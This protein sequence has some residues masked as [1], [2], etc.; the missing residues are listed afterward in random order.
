MVTLT[1]SGPTRNGSITR[2]QGAGE[3]TNPTYR[4]KPKRG[5]WLLFLC[6]MLAAMTFASPV[7]GVVVDPSA[8]LEAC[9]F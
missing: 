3:M 6:A 9:G 1:D 8:L 7:M 4:R 5:R 2:L